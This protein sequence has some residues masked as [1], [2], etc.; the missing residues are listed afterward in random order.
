MA[1][2][3]LTRLQAANTASNEAGKAGHKI[4]EVAGDAGTAVKVGVR[5]ILPFSFSLLTHG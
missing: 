5:D 3:L 1:G 4:G 2:P